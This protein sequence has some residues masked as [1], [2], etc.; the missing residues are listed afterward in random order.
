MVVQTLIQGSQVYVYGTQYA[1]V[2]F[3]LHYLN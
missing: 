1:E 2:S 3:D